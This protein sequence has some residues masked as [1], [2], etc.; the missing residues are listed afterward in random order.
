MF[1]KTSADRAAGARDLLLRLHPYETPS[2]T[3]FPIM[4]EAST[5]AF[6]SWVAAE[7]ISVPQ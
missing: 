3:A 2:L 6:L 5:S 4:A 7:T 1:A